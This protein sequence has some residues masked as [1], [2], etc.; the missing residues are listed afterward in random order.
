MIKKQFLIIAGLV[1]LSGCSDPNSEWLNKGYSVG[2][3]K[4]GWSEAN[5]E[6]QLG[7][8]GHWLK[9]LQDKGF[10][11]AAELTEGDALKQNATTLMDCINAALPVSN[12]EINYLVADC[13]KL[14][15]WSKR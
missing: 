12:G 2:L 3:D 4:K 1:A 8:A 9:S 6:T 15:G 14:S 10:L 13:V 11:N 7:T 5:A